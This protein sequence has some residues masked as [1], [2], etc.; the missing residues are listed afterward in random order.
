MV[1]DA[2]RAPPPVPAKALSERVAYVHTIPLPTIPASNKSIDN[3]RVSPS[4][5]LLQSL[6]AMLKE[7]VGVLLVDVAAV[8]VV[9]PV[10]LSRKP[11]MNLTPRWP[12]TGGLQARQVLQ[13]PILLPTPTGPP[14]PLRQ[15]V[16][17]MLVWTMKATFW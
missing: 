3:P 2:A 12:T 16:V 11:L 5:P 14:S 6:L 17:E 8:A 4:Q 9:T 13:G 7:L 15:M 1:L 10:V